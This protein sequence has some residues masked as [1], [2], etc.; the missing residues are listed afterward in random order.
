MSDMNKDDH[1]ADRDMRR[2]LLRL[3]AVGA[4]VVLTFRST[5]AWA[6]SSGCLV[7][8]GTLPIPGQLIRVDENFQPIPK[9]GI[10]AA[11]NNGNSGNCGNNGNPNGNNGNGKGKGNTNGNG[12]NGNNGSCGNNGNG[13]GSS[14]LAWYDQYETV[15]VTQDPHG[16]AGDRVADR[17][18]DINGLRALVYNGNIGTTCLQSIN[19]LS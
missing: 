2:R 14:E 13:P 3:G 7:K 4:P 5:S 12:N 17:N 8:D 9:A 10:T 18:T 16:S 6:L 19:G 15:F 11:G 1:N